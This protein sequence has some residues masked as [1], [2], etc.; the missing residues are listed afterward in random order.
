MLL[1]ANID[2]TERAG[3]HV[4]LGHMLKVDEIYFWMDSCL[5]FGLPYVSG[6]EAH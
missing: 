5:I 1:N 4:H 6:L 3:S 2:S